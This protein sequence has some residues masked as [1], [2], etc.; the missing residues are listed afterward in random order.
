MIEARMT[1]EILSQALPLASFG[2]LAL[3]MAYTAKQKT[4]IRDRD[5]NVCQFP[6]KH[7][8][9]GHVGKPLEARKLHVHHIIPQRYAQEVGIGDP[10]FVENGITI[11][12][13]SHNGPQGIHPDIAG[14]RT[15]SEFKRVFDHRAELLK[16]KKIYWNDKWDRLLHVIAVRNTQKFESSGQIF[17]P[18]STRVKQ[19]SEAV[20]D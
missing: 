6:D 12:K 5:N 14:V 20:A 15:K 2:L 11:C 1:A 13:N 9:C 16:E 18:K 4:F 3:G 10:D 7:D 19:A 8:C 17:P